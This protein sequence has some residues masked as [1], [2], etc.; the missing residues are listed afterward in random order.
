MAIAVVQAWSWSPLFVVLFVITVSFPT[1]R[2]PIG[3]WGQLARFGLALVILLAVLSVFAPTMTV[4]IPSSSSGV[5]VAN[6]LAVLPEWPGWVV[7]SAGPLIALSFTAAGVASMFVRLRRARGVERAQ[8]RWLVWSMAFIVVA[9]IVGLVGD[10]VF[11]NG[12]GGAV[13]LPAIVAFGLPPIAIGIAVLRYRLYDIDRLISR[14]V[15]YGLLT[16]IVGGLFV[17]FILVFQAVLAP[18]TQSNELA[19]AGSTLLATALFQPLRRRLQ[20][21]VDRRFNRDRYDAERTVATFAV[22]L[23]DE[24]DLQQLRAQVLATAAQTVEPR[25]LS[26]WL[27]A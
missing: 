12:L 6:P 15:T 14:T 9:F 24:V 21:L 19:V 4:N 20:R 26:L 13:W 11:V 17:G 5:T 22:G 16:A 8:L 25:S 3:R 27:R 10:S 1:G 7:L 23:R 2:L 18:V